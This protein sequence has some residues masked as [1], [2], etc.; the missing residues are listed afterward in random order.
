MDQGLLREDENGSYFVY[1]GDFGEELHD[2]NFCINGV[3]SPDRQP[4]PGL[5]EVKHH[6]QNIKVN[7]I[8]G[9]QNKYLIENRYF[10]KNLDHVEGK[11][12]FLENGYEIST[13]KIDL[14]KIGPSEKRRVDLP[15]IH[16]EFIMQPDKE[17]VADLFSNSIGMNLG[18]KKVI[19]WLWINL[20]YSLLIKF[21]IKE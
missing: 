1:G 13:G 18:Q 14:D 6:L 5:Y 10:F 9:S 2:G 3:V 17:Y 16:K 11:W 21:K 19:Y 15:N 8:N 7:Q 4:H 20:Y 12:R